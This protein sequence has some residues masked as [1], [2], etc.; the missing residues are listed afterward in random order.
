MISD[1]RKHEYRRIKHSVF[2]WSEGQPDI[3]GIAIVG[4]WSRIDAQMDSHLD[5]LVLTLDKKRYVTSDSWIS[6]ALPSPGVTVGAQTLGPLS[7]L[8]VRL[9]SG[10]IVDFGFVP[11]SWALINPVN[12]A[13]ARLVRDGC[14]PLADPEG[15]IERLIEAVSTGVR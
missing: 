8:Q 11:L 3:K 2:S 10:L 1:E 14:L 13:A 5:L 4:S 7:E 12:P 15:V 9:P 6:H